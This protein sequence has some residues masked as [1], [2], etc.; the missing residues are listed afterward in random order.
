MCG[1]LDFQ[2]GWSSSSSERMYRR[3]STSVMLMTRTETLM[4]TEEMRRRRYFK[5]T[6]T[7]E[8]P[9]PP[10]VQKLL[11]FRLIPHIKVIKVGEAINEAGE[12]HA[13]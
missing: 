5:P 11:I 9:F 2:M 8:F 12:N 13:N 10:L 6:S 4:P 7:E 3:S 1:E